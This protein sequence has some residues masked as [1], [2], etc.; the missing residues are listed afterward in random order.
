MT[1]LLQ[2]HQGLLLNTIFFKVILRGADD[3][4]NDLFVDLALQNMSVKVAPSLFAAGPGFEWLQ[5]Q[6]ITNSDDVRHGGWRVLS[7]HFSSV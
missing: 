2:F 1:N 4:L 7:L 3:F 6:G 5:D